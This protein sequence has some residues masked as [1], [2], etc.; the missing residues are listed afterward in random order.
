V[1]WACPIKGK[2]EKEGGDPSNIARQKQCSGRTRRGKTKNRSRQSAGG[3]EKHK[4]KNTTGN[5]S[6]CKEA[7][8]SIKKNHF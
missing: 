6:G 4:K 3:L 1:E 8:G 2:N 5:K 7:G